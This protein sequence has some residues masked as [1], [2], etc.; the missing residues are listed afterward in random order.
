VDADEPVAEFDTLDHLLEH[1]SLSDAQSGATLFSIF[2]FVATALA[3]FG[4]YSVVSFGV[5]QRN[6]EFAIRRALGA[7]TRQVAGIILK[8]MA[9]VTC[10]G[11][12]LGIL[13]TFIFGSILAY[14]ERGWRTND[15]IV[16][17]AV[18]VL[19]TLVST[20]A[21]LPAIARAISILPNSFL[22]TE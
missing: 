20:I 17:L 12:T 4:L 22:R 10:V 18:S 5:A 21:I 3:S 6:K 7:Q 13:G 8:W 1:S 19:L 9:G 16:L 2:A 14:Y 15:P 11:I